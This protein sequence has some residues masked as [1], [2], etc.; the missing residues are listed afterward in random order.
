VNSDKEPSGPHLSPLQRAHAA[1]AAFSPLLSLLGQE[2]RRRPVPYVLLAVFLSL[3]LVEFVFPFVPVLPWGDECIYLSNA[4]RMLEGQ[5]I[6]RDFFQF[7]TPGTELLYVLLF[8]LL[9]PRVWIPSAM[10]VLLGIVL[11]WL[12]IAI[13][14]KVLDQW[15]A[16]LAPILFLTFAFR[17]ALSATHHWYSTLAVTAA[18]AVLIEK[19][20]LARLTLGGVLCGLAL[21]FTQARGLAAILG[22][23]LFLLWENRHNK[24]RWP[25]FLRRASYLFAGFLVTVVALNGYF[26]WKAGPERFLECTV[27]FG[28]RYYPAVSEVNTLKAYMVTL[29]DVRGWADL[30]KLAVYFFIHALLPLTYVLFFIRYRHQVRTRPLEPWD[31]LMLLN[32]VGLFLFV[33][34]APAPNFFRLCTVAL[35]ALIVFVW[36]IGSP[37]KLHWASARVL[38]AF[39]LIVTVAGPWRAQRR[40]YTYLDL[41]SGRTAFPDPPWYD[42]CKWVLEHT[43]PSEFLFDA[44]GSGFYFL[45]GLRNPA[46]VPFLTPTDYT[47][48]EQVQDVVEG[49]ESR[50]V[51]YVVWPL[52]LDSWYYHNPVFDHLD[53]LR[54]YLR[55]HYH[56][57]KT[58]ENYDY[59]Q[60]WKRNR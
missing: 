9:R 24:Y 33:G 32:I 29:P 50:R 11:M 36:L 28:V 41:P 19:R 52:W 7:T 27:I 56:V 15:A 46:P 3:Y 48:P 21:C 55:H 2:F 10:L 26:V 20:G 35:P 6:Y 8:K 42:R 30:P 4:R 60:I 47:R 59:D 58:F 54:A 17:S 44:S 23:A 1:M 16:F 45:F 18:I 14:K 39:C 57:V 38:W 22:F 13:S 49:L 53:P 25:S 43:R 37:G 5:V 40:S 12:A 34:V 51:P 31:R